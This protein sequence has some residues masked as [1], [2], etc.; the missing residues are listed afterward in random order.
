M[1]SQRRWNEIE[2]TLRYIEKLKLNAIRNDA[3]TDHGSQDFRKVAEDNE[4]VIK[5]VVEEQS[6]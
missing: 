1:K 6:K 5:R 4:V 3:T 2:L